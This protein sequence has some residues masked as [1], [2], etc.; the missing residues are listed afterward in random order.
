MA[1]I[2]KE[3]VRYLAKLCRIACTEEQ[4]E[5]LLHDMQKIIGYIELLDEIDTEGLAPCNNVSESLIQAP[6]REDLTGDVLSRE[7]FLKN[8]PQHIGGLIRVP[9]VLKGA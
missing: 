6:L 2:N 1:D 9:Q 4:E 3:T 7:E 5:A 8:A